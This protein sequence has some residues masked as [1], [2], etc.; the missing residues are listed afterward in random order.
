MAKAPENNPVKRMLQ[1]KKAGLRPRINAM[2]ATCVGVTA[3]EQG[4]GMKDYM[5]SGWRKEVRQCTVL[6]C[7]LHPVRPYQS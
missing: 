3:E 2:C 6:T 1:L 4:S 5:P 7:P